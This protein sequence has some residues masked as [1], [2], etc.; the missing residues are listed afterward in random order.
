MS[1]KEQKL[2][3][4]LDEADVRRLSLGDVVYLSG[5]IYQMRGCA[6]AKVVSCLERQIP[7]PFDLGNGVI[8]HAFSLVQKRGQSWQLYYA[9]GTLSFRMNRFLPA[10]IRG[11]GIRAVVGKAGGGVGGEVLQAMRE[12]GCVHLSQIGGCPAFYRRQI[13]DCFHVYWEDL[14]NEMVLELKVDDFGPL[15]VSADTAGRQLYRPGSY[16]TQEMYR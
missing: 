6:H 1:V 8:Y 5:T 4:P 7:L 16:V 15:V 14:G 2:S 13:S 3:L 10:I 12:C 9:G 11:L